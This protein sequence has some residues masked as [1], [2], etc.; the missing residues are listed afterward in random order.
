[1]SLPFLLQLFFLKSVTNWSSR[2]WGPEVEKIQTLNLHKAPV[3]EEVIKKHRDKRNNEPRNRLSGYE[4]F[5]FK[6]HNYPL[7]VF[8]KPNFIRA[9]FVYR[10]TEANQ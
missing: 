8:T 4:F 1:M 10:Q 9:V 2:T 3:N 6:L 7:L 5:L